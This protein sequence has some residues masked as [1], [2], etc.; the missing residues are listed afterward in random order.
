MMRRMVTI[1]NKLGLHARSAARFVKLASSFDCDINVIHGDREVSG[2][3]I[4][5]VMMLAA[6]KGT[7]I[8]IVASGNDEELAVT[9]LAQLVKNQFEEDL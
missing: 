4:M 6:G 3:S 7:K 9:Q 5:G 2:K 1:T 8:E